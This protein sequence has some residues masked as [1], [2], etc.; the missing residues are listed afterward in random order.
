MINDL[1]NAHRCWGCWES[2]IS[3]QQRRGALCPSHGGR[4]E[5]HWG[6]VEACRLCLW[7]L[8]VFPS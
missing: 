2:A 3:G 8:T 7:W 6:E 5:Q 4:L 1:L